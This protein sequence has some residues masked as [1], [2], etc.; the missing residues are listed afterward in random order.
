MQSPKLGRLRLPTSYRH[1]VAILNVGRIN[2]VQP[3]LEQRQLNVSRCVNPCLIE[4]GV[5]FSI[6]GMADG[7]NA[8]APLLPF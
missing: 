5:R 3:T 2:L 1:F 7:A 6:I 4:Q 8:V